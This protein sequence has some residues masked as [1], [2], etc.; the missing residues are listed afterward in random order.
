[1]RDGRLLCLP[2]E[3]AGPRGQAEA[4]LGRQEQGALPP[5]V[6]DQSCCEDHGHDGHEDEPDVRD[7]EQRCPAALAALLDVM[8]FVDLLLKTQEVM[9][10]GALRRRLTDCAKTFARLLMCFQ[11][12]GVQRRQRPRA[13][14]S[15]RSIS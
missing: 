2:G 3:R 1:M 13:R 7:R 15:E 10:V 5:V 4:S 11:A 6:S 12:E 8:Q 9:M 14:A